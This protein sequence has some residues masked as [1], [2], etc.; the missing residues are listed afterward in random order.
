MILHPSSRTVPDLLTFHCTAPVCL[1]RFPQNY[2]RNLGFCSMSWLLDSASVPQKPAKSLR[3]PVPSS[4]PCPC[5][6]KTYQ[7]QCH[8]PRPRQKCRPLRSLPPG[9]REDRAERRFGGTDERRFWFRGAGSAALSAAVRDALH[10]QVHLPYPVLICLFKDLRS[11]NHNNSPAGIHAKAGIRV[12]PLPLH[13]LPSDLPGT[14][15]HGV[16]TV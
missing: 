5:R 11:A 9:R 6:P 16:G 8:P 7:R 15:R 3:L 10:I 1:I 12:P 13:R 2:K 4:P 14:K